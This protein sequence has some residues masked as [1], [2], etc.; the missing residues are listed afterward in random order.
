MSSA[1]TFSQTTEADFDLYA[2]CDPPPCHLIP[3]SHIRNGL[4]H[5]FTE[6]LGCQHWRDASLEARRGICSTPKT[7]N[8]AEPLVACG[9]LAGQLKTTQNAS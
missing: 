3:S 5:P 9:W 7:P 6:G 4:R 8:D 2:Y 1:S